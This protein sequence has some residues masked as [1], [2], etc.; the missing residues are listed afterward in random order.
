[1]TAPVAQR[2]A[3][4]HFYSPLPDTRELASRHDALWPGTPRAMPGVDLREDA[5]LDFARRV[6]AAQERM[7]FADRAKDPSTYFIEND[8]FPPADAWTLEGVL[9]HL[10]PRRMIEIG[11]GNST[12]VSARVS[13]EHLGGAMDLTCIEPYPAPGLADID[14]VTRLR[15]ER[16]ELTPPAVFEALGPG[17]VLFIDTSHVAKTGSDVVWIYQEVV[18]RVPAGVW[19]HVHDMFLPWDYP[20]HWVLDGWG[21]NEQYLV[22]AFLAFNAA[23]RIEFAVAWMLSHHPAEMRRALPGLQNPAYAARNG[24]SL[25]ISRV[26]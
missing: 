24:A 8:Q 16:V 4:G 11:S 23:F 14:G 20:P 25:W 19:V 6:L 18:P 5:Q 15:V 3:P 10:R 1:M 12:R 26:Q 17:D 21:W 9:R 13:R 2:F 22:R 7:P